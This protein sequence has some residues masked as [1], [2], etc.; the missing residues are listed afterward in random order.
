[1]N[2]PT[3]RAIA[4]LIL[5]SSL[6]GLGQA[7]AAAAPGASE[8]PDA[9]TTF[10][11]TLVSLRPTAA[12]QMLDLRFKVIDPQKAR[13]LLAKSSKAY[14]VDT[15][16]GK[17]LPVPVTKA[18]SMRQTTPKP[19]AGRVYFMLF[20]NPGRLVKEGSRVDLAIGEFRKVG[21]VVDA[22]GALAERP[23]PVAG[24]PGG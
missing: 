13:P 7:D 23:D 14:L 19:E 1:M 6:A 24:K 20:S 10:G 12:G 16:S 11:I 15:A 3:F 2:T 5:L 17:V 18:G 9:E 21:V 22:S 8:T 4:T